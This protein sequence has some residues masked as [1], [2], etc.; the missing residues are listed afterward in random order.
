MK[1]TEISIE[2]TYACSMKCKMCSSCADFPTPIKNELTFPE[3]QR[4]LDTGKEMGCE[5]I[6]WSGGDPILRSDFW[7]LVDYA[8]KLGYRQLL[9]T[10][11]IKYNGVD[12]EPLSDYELQVIKKYG[13]TMIFDLQSH[14]PKI[15]DKIMDVPG[16]YDLEIDVIE[17]ARKLGVNLETHFVPQKDN[18]KDI[19][20]Y[21]YF[22]QELG[23]RKISFL[24][25]VKQGR[26][27]DNDVMISQKQFRDM[28]YLLYDLMQR[29]DLDIKI[30]LGHP[31]NFLFLVEYELTGK[32]PDEHG[33]INGKFIDCC[34]GGIDA[35]LIKPNG[36]VDVCPAWKDLNEYVAGNIRKESLKDI[37]ESSKTYKVFRWFIHK[38]G[39]KYV[40]NE[41]KDCPFLKWCKCKC[42]AQRLLLLDDRYDIRRDVLIAPK[43]P[44][45]WYEL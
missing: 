42:V 12:R 1:P 31:I 9:Y 22:C 43:D 26:A 3:I 39:W 8:S 45:C 15:H 24:R 21:V 36:D 32:L 38:G 27:K 41:C 14:R 17:R 23:I 28:Q 40:E 25:C 20:D 16:A 34:R 7:V 18:I 44:M 10:T 37:W 11:G 5:Y 6:S 30:R 35:P 4:V 19:E 29:K 33:R 13:M 2:T